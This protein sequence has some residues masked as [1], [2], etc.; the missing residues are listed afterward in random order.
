MRLAAE[1]VPAVR[2]VASIDRLKF[3]APV[4]PGAVLKLSLAH[5]V[6]RRRVQFAYRM[7]GRECA[8]GVIVYGEAA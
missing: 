2:A 8:S 3:M 5:D 6:G 4:S 1:H 7:N